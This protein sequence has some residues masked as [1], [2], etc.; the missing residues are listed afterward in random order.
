[1]SQVDSKKWISKKMEE[2]KQEEGKVKK[3]VH[4][5]DE[6]N[7]KK[8]NKGEKKNNNSRN[9]NSRNN[10][11]RNNNSRNNNSRNNNSRNNNSRNNNSIKYVIKISNLPNDISVRELNDLIL[12][13]GHIGNINFGKSHNNISYIDFFDKNE[14]EYFV[15]ALDRT[16]FDNLIIAVQLLK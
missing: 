9:N 5:D 1:M 11:S 2:R 16:P 12:P 8:Y 6:N 7:K 10:N 15:K 14:A 13:W 3:T 4:K